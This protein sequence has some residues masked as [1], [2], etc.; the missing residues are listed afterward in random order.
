VLDG[1][2]VT[3][4]QTLPDSGAVADLQGQG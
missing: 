2:R 4:T 3:I 1:E